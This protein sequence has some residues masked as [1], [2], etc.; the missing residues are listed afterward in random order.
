MSV[1]RTVFGEIDGQ[2]VEAFD[3]ERGSLRARVVT[4]G[5]VLS[6]MHV[7]D[8]SGRT[9]DIALGYDD[10]ESYL[11]F[12]GSAGAVCGRYANRIADG[13][14]T[15]DGQVFQLSQNEPPNHLHGGFKGFSKRVWNAEPDGAGCA[16]RLT[17]HRPDGDEGY[18]G[19]VA[20]AVTY[21]LLDEPALEIVMEATTDKPTVVNMAFH[22]YWNLAGHGAGSVRDQLL[23]IDADRYTPVGPDKIPTG[24]L[25][26]V[27]GTAFDFGQERPIGAFFEDRAQLPEG[28]Y[29]HNFCLTGAG[30]T[31]R[32]AARACDP[33]SGRALEIWTDQPGVQLYTAN[34]FANLPAVGKGGAAY[35]KHAGFALETQVFPNSPNVPCF[36]SALLRPGEV[37]RHTMRIPFLI[38]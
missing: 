16:V 26:P 32:R 33:A 2:A 7:P 3:L 6:E 19:A 31:L 35:G 28:G 12:R 36:P 18:P 21:R 25:A 17:L 23:A 27:T 9:E 5:A 34:H 30:G 14:I 4:Y 20:A 1:H 8:R 24:V 15:V 37:Y 38:A 13:R 29:D 22:G 10:L 11:R